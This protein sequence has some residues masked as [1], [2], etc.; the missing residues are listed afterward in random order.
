[1]GLALT[2]PLPDVL[3]EEWISTCVLA[4]PKVVV[5]AIFSS[6]SSSKQFL[7][8]RRANVKLR[9]LHMHILIRDVP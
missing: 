9:L 3:K 8:L 7:G 6:V 5:G 1:M 4:Q 2:W